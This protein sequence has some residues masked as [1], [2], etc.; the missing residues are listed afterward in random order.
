MTIE[1]VQN[2]LLKR[3]INIDK[4]FLLE[5]SKRNLI[6]KLY[7]D[8]FNSF[9]NDG[10]MMPGGYKMH[11]LKIYSIF[12]TLVNN[13]HLVTRREKNINSIIE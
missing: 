5:S 13:G 8:L 2:E 9:Y 11:H 4:L 7:D 10:V 6:I 12:N 1:D 3:E